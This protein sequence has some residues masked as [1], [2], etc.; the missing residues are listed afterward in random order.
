MTVRLRHVSPVNG[1]FD[2]PLKGVYA[3][4]PVFEDAVVPVPYE[5]VAG[6]MVFRLAGCPRASMILLDCPV[7]PDDAVY[8]G[9]CHLRSDVVFVAEPTVDEP[10]ECFLIE[11]PV[12]PRGR[13]DH[14]AT[15]KVSGARIGERLRL[16]GSRFD[17]HRVGERVK[18]V[19]SP[20]PDISFNNSCYIN[21]LL[22]VMEGDSSPP[23]RGGASSP[24]NRETLAR[25]QELVAS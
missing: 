19:A 11:R 15:V 6:G 7:V 3:Q 18:H 4:S 12:L 23:A 1:D 14:V 21:R 16:V 9:T 20:L 17:T 24:K 2:S 25:R 22:K 10:V 5:V 8:G 13:A